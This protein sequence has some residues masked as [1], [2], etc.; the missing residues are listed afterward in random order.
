MFDDEDD[1]TC[2][3]CGEP[4]PPDEATAG[5]WACR[6]HPGRCLAVRECC[7]YSHAL[8]TT[9]RDPKQNSDAARRYSILACA[10]MDALGCVRADHR[11][12]G[13]PP[14]RWIAAVSVVPASAGTPLAAVVLTAHVNMAD[15]DARAPWRVRVAV[16]HGTE[17][18]REHDVTEAARVALLTVYARPAFY[19][20][21]ETWP[22]GVD[23]L[24]A[25]V[26]QSARLQ[27]RAGAGAADGGA[28]TEEPD[29]S[30]MDVALFLAQY[31]QGRGP[32]VTLQIVRRAAPTVDPA[33]V[34]R[35][36]VVGQ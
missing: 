8:V 20:A 9:L 23:H 33:I 13:V 26:R 12:R 7:G 31:Q 17:R 2:A 5:Q 4:L 28:M 24:R 11:P 32:R 19:G 34:G 18:T 25:C 30:D 27:R 21:P 29:V 35:Y 16:A 3:E 6:L 36:R 14:E 1:G 15:L 22:Q 10:G